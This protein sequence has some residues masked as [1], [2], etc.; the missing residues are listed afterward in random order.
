MTTSDEPA[1]A[2]A[3]P[4]PPRA[5]PSADTGAADTGAGDTGAAD[6]GSGA[7]GA[8]DTGAG[9]TASGDAASAP[10]GAGA[11][12][13]ARRALAARTWHNLRALVLEENDRRREVVDALGM[14][15]VRI[16]ALRR[17]AAAPATLRALAA[18]LA[19]DAPYT[20]VV[21]DDLARR[22]LVERTPHPE[23]RRAKIVSVTEAGRAAAA[24]ADRI[25]GE[26]P[27]ALLALPPDDAAALDRITAALRKRS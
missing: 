24:E 13:A 22:G 14:S 4:D 6:T 23:D 7:A 26:P 3:A 2:S 1:S 9:D 19:T 10:T 16:K 12:S 27:E 5:R 8:A 15:F 11:P 21:V 17:L 25:L 18:D 20:T